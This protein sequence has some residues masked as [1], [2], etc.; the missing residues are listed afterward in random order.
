MLKRNEMK[1]NVETETKRK[2]EPEWAP[3]L[4]LDRRPCLVRAELGLPE[5]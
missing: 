5:A 1:D 3:D 2:N 4:V